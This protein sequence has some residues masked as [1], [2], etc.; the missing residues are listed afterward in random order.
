MVM[1]PT[2]VVSMFTPEDFFLCWAGFMAALILV[3][4]GRQLSTHQILHCPIIVNYYGLK[5]VLV[6]VILTMM[7]SMV[8]IASDVSKI[9]LPID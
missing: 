5:I 2:V 8:V 6:E 9:K 7:V 4:F 1:E 3:I